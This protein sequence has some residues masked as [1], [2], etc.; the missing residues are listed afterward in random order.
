MAHVRRKFVDA[1]NADHR[2]AEI[3]LLISDLYWI[4]ADCRIHLLSKDERVLE[5]QHRSLPILSQLWQFLKPI[6]D[7]TDGF[8]VNL[9]IKAVR[10][11]VNEW[12]AICRYV[13]MVRLRLITIPPSV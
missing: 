9:F 1:L 6:F 3:I 12:E 2:S 11:A 10:Y 13:T 7:E 8:A 5:R 4:E